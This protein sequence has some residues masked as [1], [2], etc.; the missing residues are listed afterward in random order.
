MPA[1]NGHDANEIPEDRRAPGVGAP[2]MGVDIGEYLE[3]QG[4]DDA[5]EL[6][7]ANDGIGGSFFKLGPDTERPRGEEGGV[8]YA[9]L[10]ESLPESFMQAVA[11]ELLRQIDEDKEARKKRD[12]QYEEGIKRTGLGKDAPGGADFEGASK[13]VHPMLTEA[14]V[15]YESRVIKELFPPSGP[16]KEKI[17]GTVTEEKAERAKRKVEHMN[18]QITTQIVEAFSVMETTLTQVPL[19]G[20]QFIKQWWDHRLGRPRWQFVPI[21]KVYL[22]FSAESFNSSHRRTFVD[23]L[24][25]VEFQQRIETKQYRDLK[26]AA[27]SAPPDPTKAETANRKVEGLEDPGLNIDQ[28]REVYEVM[29][30]IEVKDEASDVLSVEEVGKLYPYL[31]SIDVTTKRV[32]SWYRDWEKDDDTREPIE[33]LF[34]FPFIPWRGAYSIGFPQI[35]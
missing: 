12:E 23:T 32:L 28:E 34:E 19:G 8:F 22:P 18:W 27:P 31:I 5:L 35:I 13:V 29:S 16:A 6:E 17:V 11:T 3:I 10:A 15:D 7:D 21:D 33:H 30:Y 14:C 26:L 24:T 20:S 2:A 1:L 4:D 9:N 25:A